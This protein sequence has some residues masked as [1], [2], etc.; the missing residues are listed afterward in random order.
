M[1]FGIRVYR[2]TR[3]LSRTHIEVDRFIDLFRDP[4]YFRQGGDPLGRVTERI[5]RQW[6]VFRCLARRFNKC[7][8]VTETQGFT[9]RIIEDQQ[10]E[11]TDTAAI[12]GVIA[13]MAAVRILE[14]ET[15]RALFA[16]RAGYPVPLLRGR[17]VRN[18]AVVA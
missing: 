11:H 1:K 7:G 18:R 5:D 16:N 2:L 6:L 10:F 4:E 14:F 17:L 13:T 15:L 12:A 3:L 9:H 8:G